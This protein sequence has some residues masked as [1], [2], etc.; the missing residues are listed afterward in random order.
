MNCLHLLLLSNLTPAGQLNLPSCIP[1]LLGG[2]KP[3]GV[4][5]VQLAYICKSASREQGDSS[6]RSKQCP[7]SSSCPQLY[8]HPHPPSE[9]KKT[10]VHFSLSSE[11][12]QTKMSHLQEKDNP[13]G[14]QR[15]QE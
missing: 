7:S 4:F 13:A 8:C 6:T 9:M 1:D 15:I 12:I 3:V 5:G 10:Q 11:R 14:S 2:T